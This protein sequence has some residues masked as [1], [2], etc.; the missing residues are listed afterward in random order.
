[1]TSSWSEERIRDLQDRFL[2]DIENVVLE[3]DATPAGGRRA[4]MLSGG[5]D[6]LLL[7]VLL[8]RLFP[9]DALESI[10]VQGL[11]G[12]DSQG[13]Q[14][15]ADH[16]GTTHHVLGVTLDDIF[17]NLHRIAGTGIAS[18]SRLMSHVCYELCLERLGVGGTTLYHG[19][20]ADALYGNS[21]PVRLKVEEL[22]A[23]GV[24]PDEA[25]V[26]VKRARYE[27][28]MQ[29]KR[30]FLLLAE[31]LGAWAVM[32]YTDERL[33]YMCDVPFSILDPSDKGFV[34]AAMRHRYGLGDIVE[35]PR[36]SMQA[37]TGLRPELEKELRQR[38]AAR[39]RRLVEIVRSLSS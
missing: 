12:E 4:V 22:L 9:E 1:M 28:E 6:S 21:R 23:A 34:K 37:G 3:S 2:S 15:V 7:V 25:G 10:H 17:D 20:G 24:T 16:F 38:F 32:P 5:L 33:A 26:R 19:D 31:R 36:M 35:R 11:P 13:A 27:E 39:G 30:Y 14:M 18:V 8:R 29:D